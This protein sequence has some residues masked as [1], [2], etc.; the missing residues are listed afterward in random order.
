M[1]PL[2]PPV[3]GTPGSGIPVFYYVYILF[4]S[5]CSGTKIFARSINIL[6][7]ESG[8]FHLNSKTIQHKMKGYFI[9]IC[10]YIESSKLGNLRVS[11]GIFALKSIH[12]K[13]RA[14]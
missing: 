6:F 5:T 10:K 3:P 7:L 14:F 11:G 12:Y 9:F 8:P 13:R 1:P 2:V 4:P